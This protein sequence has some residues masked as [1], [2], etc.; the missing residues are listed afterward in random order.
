MKQT[1]QTRINNFNIEAAKLYVGERIEFDVLIDLIR[2]RYYRLLIQDS[3]QYS[4]FTYEQ[5]QIL[6][7][8]FKK[9]KLMII[10][11]SFGTAYKKPKCNTDIM[12][13]CDVK[14]FFDKGEVIVDSRYLDQTTSV[15][16]F[17]PGRKKTVNEPTLFP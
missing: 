14:M 7:D 5:L 8:L 1:I 15:K 4:Q 16:L 2:K 13:A 9:R 10:L 11:V 6:N 12:H 3:V 17:T